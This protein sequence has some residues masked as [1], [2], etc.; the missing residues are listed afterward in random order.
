MRIVRHSSIGPL[1]LALALLLLIAQAGALAHA[2]AHEP[3]NLQS[4]ICA[5]CIAAESL[6]SACIDTISPS[7]A[8]DCRPASGQKTKPALFSVHIPLARQ[9]SPPTSI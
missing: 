6:S 4:K 2:Y 9:R 5:T 1:S 3:S 8:L 7:E